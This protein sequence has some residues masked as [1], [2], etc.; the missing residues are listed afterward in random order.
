MSILC[1]LEHGRGRTKVKTEDTSDQQASPG[2][3]H[4]KRATLE[5]K[6]L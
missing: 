1:I 3:L 2:V 5:S 6:H 4:K